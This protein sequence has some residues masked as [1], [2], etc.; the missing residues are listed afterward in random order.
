MLGFCGAAIVRRSGKVG[1]KMRSQVGFFVC[2]G[3]LFEMD[4]W[5]FVHG[6]SLVL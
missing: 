4:V 3:G 1:V 5:M 6:L 2:I